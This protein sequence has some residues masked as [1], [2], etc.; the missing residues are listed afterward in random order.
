MTVF[1]NL[2]RDVPLLS[3]LDDAQLKRVAT[4][5]ERASFSAGDNIIEA[6]S[7][8]D[9]AFVLIDGPV[10]CLST[11]SGET[12]AVRIPA[13]STILEL[14]MIV[15]IE[16]SATCVARGATKALRLPR[17]PLQTLMENDTELTDA[18]I[19]SLT[20]RLNEMADTMRAADK[21]FEDVRQ[22]A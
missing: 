16:A 14:A 11:I 12:H 2:L 8:A 4:V 18:I 17:A 20:I 10:D 5:C 13:G 22:S 6:G 19:T 9:A 1:V 21:V 7:T 15:D 3:Q